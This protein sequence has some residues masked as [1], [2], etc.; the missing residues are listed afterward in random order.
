MGEQQEEVLTRFYAEIISAGLLDADLGTSGIGRPSLP[1]VR[2]DSED[3]SDP[4]T[5]A[6]F[7]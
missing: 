2:M 4:H 1:T 7:V 3:P 6:E 5:N